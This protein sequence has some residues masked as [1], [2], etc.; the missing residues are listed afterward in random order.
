MNK[1]EKLKQQRQ[2]HENEECNVGS[3]VDIDI[4]HEIC[5]GDGYLGWDDNYFC[6]LEQIKGEED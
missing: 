2:L 1:E 3:V 4:F 6:I 5:D